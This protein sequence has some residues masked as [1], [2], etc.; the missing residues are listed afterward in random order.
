LEGS[1]AR[2]TAREGVG[3]DTPCG[4]GKILLLTVLDKT[5]R[6][7]PRV[8]FSELGFE[9]GFELGLGLGLRVSN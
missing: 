4:S 1:D 8:P 6:V 9:L 5:D 2:G 3:F 7:G